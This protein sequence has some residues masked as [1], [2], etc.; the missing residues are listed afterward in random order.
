MPRIKK[1]FIVRIIMNSMLVKL[2]D[3]VGVC[4]REYSDK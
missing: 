1:V 2:G 4:S 3:E